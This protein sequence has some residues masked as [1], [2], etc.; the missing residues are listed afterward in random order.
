MSRYLARL[1][2][3]EAAIPSPQVVTEARRQ[4]DL[5]DILEQAKAEAVFL[6]TATS[7][8]RVLI[9]REHVAKLE[10]QRAESTQHT[11]NPMLGALRK[12]HKVWIPSFLEDALADVRQAE[13]DLIREAGFTNLDQPGAREHLELQLFAA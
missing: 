9:H 10:V 13:L 4:M 8:Q 3:L 7:L 5:S 11:D 2:K 1:A 12:V 6:E